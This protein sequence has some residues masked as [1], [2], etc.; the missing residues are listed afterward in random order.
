MWYIDLFLKNKCVLLIPISI[1]KVKL[2]PILAVKKKIHDYKWNG[3]G[4]KIV[5]GGKENVEF[6]TESMVIRYQSI[7]LFN[8]YSVST[9]HMPGCVGSAGYSVVI[10][11][12]EE[13]SST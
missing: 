12:D 4:R 5:L 7:H 1:R 13:G 11:A 10:T 6:Q 2:D 8:K 9:H 3:I